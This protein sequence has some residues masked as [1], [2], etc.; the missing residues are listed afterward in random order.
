MYAYSYSFFHSYIYIY[1]FYAYP[2][3]HPLDTRSQLDLEDL[4]TLVWDTY[5]Y[6]CI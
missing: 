6:V 4:G 2:I 1:I 3:H 5:I